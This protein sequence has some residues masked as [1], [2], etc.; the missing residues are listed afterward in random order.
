MHD[1]YLRRCHPDDTEHPYHGMSYCVWMKL[2][3]V[4]PSKG[5]KPVPD[6][7]SNKDDESSS[8]DKE[9]GDNCEDSCDDATVTNTLKK[10]GRPACDR[11]E[12][13]G[14]PKISKLQVMYIEFPLSTSFIVY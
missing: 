4:E 2:V 3:R 9:D 14:S 12:F 11:Y 13:V 1:L 7:T 8:S 10:K 6:D 5:R